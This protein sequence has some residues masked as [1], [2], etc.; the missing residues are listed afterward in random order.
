MRLIVLRWFNHLFGSLN[1]VCSLYR[2]DIK[3]LRDS[4]DFSD[5]VGCI[6]GLLSL[7]SGSIEVIFKYLIDLEYVQLLSQIKL[8]LRQWL[9]LLD[10]LCQLGRYLSPLL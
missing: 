3:R 2:L 4:L 9:H 7:A 6:I 8:P 1:F 10:L 5:V